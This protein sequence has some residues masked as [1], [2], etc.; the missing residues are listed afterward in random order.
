M[1]LVTVL[2]D[3]LVTLKQF[4]ITQGIIVSS[5]ERILYEKMDKITFSTKWVPQYLRLYEERTTPHISH[6]LPHKLFRSSR[7]PG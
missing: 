6:K 7:D 2:G 5:I 4:A 1:L 3:R